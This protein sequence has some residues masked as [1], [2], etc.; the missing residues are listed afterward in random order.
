[1][2]IIKIDPI[3]APTMQFNN[4]LLNL[5]NQVQ[6][7]TVDPPEQID[8]ERILAK[9]ALHIRQS[10]NLDEVLNTAVAEVRQFLQTDR[11]VIYRFK[12]DWN[13]I[14]VVE[15]VSPDWLPTLGILI[16]DTCFTTETHILPYKLG[17]VR[18]IED[19]YT[20]DIAQCHVELLARFQVR[21]NLVVPILQGENLWGLLIAHHCSAPRRWQ[22]WEIDLLEQLATHMAIA[23]Q[24]SELYLQSQ[25]ELINRQRAEAALQ[26]AKDELEIKVA[27]RTRE[28]QTTNQLMRGEIVERQQVEAALQ[29]SQRKLNTLID[30]LPGIVF[31]SANTLSGQ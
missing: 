16:P 26:K 20:E 11:V 7:S 24:Q 27:E 28:L 2:G 12:P 14:V 22:P 6:K 5:E 4:R 30:S 17:R 18:A 3:S 9:I 8:Y 19:I 25:T 21:S 29:K 15:S 1:M 13:G 10:L 31:S 23:I